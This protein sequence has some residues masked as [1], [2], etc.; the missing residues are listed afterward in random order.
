MK[1]IPALKAIEDEEI[2]GFYATGELKEI[3]R[4]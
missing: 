2:F 3:T 1:A 4:N